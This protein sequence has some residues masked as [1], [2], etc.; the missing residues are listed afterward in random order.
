M[1]DL[2]STRPLTWTS[3]DA[4]GGMQSTTI[5]T[6]PTQHL[7]DEFAVFAE[8]F[9]DLDGVTPGVSLGRYRATGELVEP[10]GMSPEVARL[11]AAALMTAADRAEGVVS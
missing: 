9:F 11:L 1:F 8:Q 2:D 3:S 10:I 5:A 4:D 6:L 7:G